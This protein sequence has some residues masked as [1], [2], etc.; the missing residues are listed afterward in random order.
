MVVQSLELPWVG[1]G[2]DAW[3][4]CAKALLMMAM[5][6]NLKDG[7]GTKIH[8]VRKHLEQTNQH[9]KRARACVVSGLFPRRPHK[10][11]SVRAARQNSTFFQGVRTPTLV[12]LC[13]PEARLHKRRLEN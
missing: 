12:Y 2:Q 5:L 7:K 11:L 8:L 9:L 13:C 4:V 3:P 6:Q 1:V 10:N